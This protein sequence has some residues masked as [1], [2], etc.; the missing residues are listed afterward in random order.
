[1][2]AGEEDDRLYLVIQLVYLLVFQRITSL[3]HSIKQFLFANRAVVLPYL[4]LGI[5]ADTIHAS[6]GTNVISVILGNLR[7]VLA[8][9][10]DFTYL[11]G[12]RAREAREVAQLSLGHQPAFEDELRF[13]NGS[14]AHVWV[15]VPGVYTLRAWL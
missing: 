3:I 1:M 13:L 2:V 9:L 12:Q 14:S 5:C 10:D 11:L 8:C 7:A 6:D 15:E 4:I